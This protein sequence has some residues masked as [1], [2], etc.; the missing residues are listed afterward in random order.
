MTRLG[1]ESLRSESGYSL[2]EQWRPLLGVGVCPDAKIE[3]RLLSVHR[4]SICA[5]I[6]FFCGQIPPWPLLAAYPVAALL[7]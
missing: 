7:P 3:L 2:G 6:Y 5:Y 4:F 1:I